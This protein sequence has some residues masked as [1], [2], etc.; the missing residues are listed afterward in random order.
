MKHTTVKPTAIYVQTDCAEGGIAG[1]L[2]TQVTSFDIRSGTLVILDG[3]KIV[4]A[5]A[6]GSWKM[7]FL[8]APKAPPAEIVEMPAA[9]TEVPPAK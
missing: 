6:P 4:H 5:Y 3:H 1:F 8:G 7:V 2:L 9:V